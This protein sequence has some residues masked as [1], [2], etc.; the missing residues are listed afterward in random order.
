MT[1]SNPGK[2]QQ[3]G[4]TL[5]TQITISAFPKAILFLPSVTVAIIAT[6]NKKYEISSKCYRLEARKWQA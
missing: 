3:N 5:T 6:E 2:V 1:Q 4:F